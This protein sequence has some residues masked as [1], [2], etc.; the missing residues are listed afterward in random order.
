MTWLVVPA[1]PGSRQHVREEEREG[2]VRLRQGLQG[3]SYESGTT[4]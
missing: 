3:P 4:P 1:G 2:H